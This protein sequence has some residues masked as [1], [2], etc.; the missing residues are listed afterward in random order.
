MAK[1]GD[2][3]QLDEEKEMTQKIMQGDPMALRRARLRIARA[4][5]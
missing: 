4:A 2:Y 5:S 1:Q 3:E